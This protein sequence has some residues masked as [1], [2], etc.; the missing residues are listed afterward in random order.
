MG[1]HNEEMKHKYGLYFLFL[2]V[3][4]CPLCIECSQ[5]KVK[6][7]FQ[8]QTFIF[9]AE[10]AVEETVFN[11]EWVHIGNIQ[12]KEF[13]LPECLFSKIVLIGLQLRGGT[14]LACLKCKILYLD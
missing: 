13:T 1:S 9:S 14:Q 12:M 2:C 10:F 3:Y 8:S 6:K 5:S 4:L 7:A 11:N